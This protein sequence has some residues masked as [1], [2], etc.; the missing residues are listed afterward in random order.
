MG[1]LTT[2]LN[3]FR[4]LSTAGCRQLMHGCLLQRP[5][6]W[7]SSTVDPT[8]GAP[9]S[10][11]HAPGCSLCDTRLWRGMSWHAESLRQRYCASKPVVPQVQRLHTSW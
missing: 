10:R 6:M 4:I 3:C 11:G 2:I 1:Q 7:Q 5:G 8:W 9:P